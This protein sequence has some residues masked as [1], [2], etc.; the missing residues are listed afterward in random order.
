MNNMVN[1]CLLINK[2]KGLTSRQEVNKISKILKTKKVGHIGTLDPF[3]TGLLIVLVGNAT[4]ISPFLEKEDKTYIAS[5]KF[6]EATDTLDVDGNVIK[7][8]EVPD[9]SID[10]IKEVLKS[11]IGESEQVPPLYSALKLN[12]KHYYDYARKGIEIERKVRKIRIYDIQFVSYSNHVL[13]FAAKVSKGTYIR[14]LGEDIATR[15]GTIGH[16]IEL[17]RL[18]IGDFSLSKAIKSDEV[19]ETKLISID[20]ML[21]DYKNI[22]LDDKLA[23]KAKNGVALYLNSQEEYVLVSDKDGIIAMYQKE[24]DKYICLRG[25]R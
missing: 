22:L 3:A 11:F 9:L 7:S 18:A 24:N 21:K 6:G 17:E 2:E 25:L 15:L 10:K 19:D 16:L 12:G 23:L 8:E 4:K 13:T 20:K 5:L 14:S 1:G